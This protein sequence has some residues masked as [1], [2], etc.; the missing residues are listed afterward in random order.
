MDDRRPSKENCTPGYAQ[1]AVQLDRMEGSLQHVD[2]KLGQVLERLARM[3]Q[4]QDSQAAEIES[5]RSQLE[6]HDHR[7]RT[8]EVNQAVV[9]KATQNADTR[10]DGRWSNLGAVGLVLLGAIVTVLG[11]GLIDFLLSTGG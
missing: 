1:L 7:L 3:E 5:H 2:K 10:S 6:S 11:K 9:E 8:V 4:R